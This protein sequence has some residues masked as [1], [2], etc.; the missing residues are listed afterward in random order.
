MSRY[1]QFLGLPVTS[2]CPGWAF[3]RPNA[4]SLAQK[5][6]EVFSRVLAFFLSF[7]FLS[8]ARR[9]FRNLTGEETEVQRDEIISSGSEQL[10]AEAP[11]PRPVDKLLKIS[12]L[13]PLF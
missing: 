11:K 8:S 7:S 3:I 2:R 12:L 13:K 10:V 4:S 9:N 6:Q 5:P 1:Q